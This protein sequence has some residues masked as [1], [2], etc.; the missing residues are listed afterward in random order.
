MLYTRRLTCAAIPS[1]RLRCATSLYTGEAMFGVYQ[2]IF[3]P[4]KGGTYLLILPISENNPKARMF[5]T[6]TLAP[7]GMENW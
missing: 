1:A 3:F 5:T 4:I 6:T 2:T 7:A